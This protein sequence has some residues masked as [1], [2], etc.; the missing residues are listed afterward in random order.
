MWLNSEKHLVSITSVKAN[1]KRTVMH[2]TKV[3]VRS[4]TST[5]PEPR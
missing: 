1:A 3:T 5:H 4:A 2:P